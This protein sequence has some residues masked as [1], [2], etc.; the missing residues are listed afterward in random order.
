[1]ADQDEEKKDGMTVQEIENMAKKY[2]FELVF[3]LAFVL[4][5]VFSYLFNIMGWCIFLASIGGIVGVCLPNHID[6]WMGSAF[7]FLFKQET[8]TQ[9]VVGVVLIVLSI[10]ISPVIYVL[11][12]LLGGVETYQSVKR[13]QGGGGEPS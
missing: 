2:R 7:G 10:V 11:L 9:I 13:N 8:V 4:A 12:G 3:C 5:A 1:M 6:S